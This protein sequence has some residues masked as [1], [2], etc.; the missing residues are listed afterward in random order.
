MSY[1]TCHDVKLESYQCGPAAWLL[2]HRKQKGLGCFYST[3]FGKTLTSVSVSVSLFKANV[4]TNI[5]GITPKSL[6]ENLKSGFKQCGGPD[7]LR[8]LKATRFV[9][10]EKVQ[11]DPSS[12]GHI[13]SSTLIILDEAHRLRESGTSTYKTIK[14]LCSRAGKVLILTATP[15]VNSPG[16][17]LSLLRLFAPDL[18]LKTTTPA[19]FR[20]AV[21]HLVAFPDVD[22]SSEFPTLIKEV[23]W[24][25]LDSNQASAIQAYDRKTSKVQSSAG[26]N[27]YLVKTRQ[28]SLGIPP[29]PSSK[30]Y[31]LAKTLDKYPGRALV[32]TEYLQSGVDYITDFLRARLVGQKVEALTGKTDANKRVELVNLFN[33][34]RVDVLVMSSAGQEGL[35][36]KEVRSIHHVNADWNPADVDQKDGRGRRYRSHSNLPASERVVRSFQYI[37]LPVNKSN[38]CD[39]QV[40]GECTEFHLYEVEQKKR[41]EIGKYMA[42]L[43]NASIPHLCD[44]PPQVTKPVADKGNKRIPMCSAALLPVGFSFDGFNGH[45]YQVVQTPRGKRWKHVGEHDDDISLSEVLKKVHRLP[46]RAVRFSDIPEEPR[47]RQ[48][49]G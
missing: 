36:F 48:R 44:E 37:S 20:S 41:R 13:S 35:D 22:K 12:A 26:K 9:T 42:E 8:T 28:L 2:K 40:G 43:I 38:K 17:A 33:T 27:S 6:V 30:L 5:V 1:K 7:A 21:Q 3:G 4:I 32:F 16:D 29:T 31:A 15:M 46:G 10:Y 39:N 24:V 47:R 19:G 23:V 34:K 49:L 45:R 11:S 25:T 18:E 14:D